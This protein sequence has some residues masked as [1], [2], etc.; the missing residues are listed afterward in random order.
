MSRIFR[1]KIGDEWKMS[2]IPKK[3]RLLI[4]GLDIPK[5]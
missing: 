3:S 4:E 2:E 5:V 1:L